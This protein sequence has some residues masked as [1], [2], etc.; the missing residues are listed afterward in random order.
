MIEKSSRHKW[1]KTSV[2]YRFKENT[3]FL[4]NP[5]VGLSSGFSLQHSSVRL[6]ISGKEVL[7]SPNEGRRGDRPPL[8]NSSIVP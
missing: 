7:F 3:V 4:T 2:L 8:F 1:V 5:M 6:R